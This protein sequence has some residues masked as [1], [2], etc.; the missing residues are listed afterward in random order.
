MAEEARR[1]S[2]ENTGCS[3]MQ[4][5]GVI[6]F[7]RERMIAMISMLKSQQGQ[8]LR[9][10]HFKNRLVIFNL[11]AMPRRRKLFSKKLSGSDDMDVCERHPSVPTAKASCQPGDS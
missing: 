7:A 4:W 11:Q 6:C 3:S 1:D 2:G 8:A 5:E 9:W 10:P